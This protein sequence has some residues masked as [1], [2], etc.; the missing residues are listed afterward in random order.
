LSK[1]KRTRLSAEE[2][3][4]LV[5]EAAIAVFAER[6]YRGAS[7][8]EIARRAGVTVPVVYDHA[9]NKLELYRRLLEQTRNGLLE[10]WRDTLFGHAA[11]EQRIQ[12]GIEAWAQFVE[13]NRD[14]TRMYFREASGGDPDAE[15]IQ[16]EIT[17]QARVALSIVLG[18]LVA[19][20]HDQEALE[21]H[22]EIIR[23]G[24]VGLALWW[25]DHQHIARERIVA[26]GLDVLWRGYLSDA[27]QTIR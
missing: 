17:G 16:R 8:D 20:P 21:M 22:A 4:K 6:G 7:M 26:A 5:D 27:G 11:F 2:R 18:Q 13:P 14:A 1:P 9:D 23:S 3:R 15:A 24:L 25:Y 12:T 19:E 10:M